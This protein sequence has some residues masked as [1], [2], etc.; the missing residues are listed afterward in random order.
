MG[1]LGVG[2][3]V[4][5]GVSKRFPGQE[6]GP[7]V[8]AVT[9]VD[10]SVDPGDSLAL[11]GPN[12]AGKSTVLKLVAGVT[13][14]SAG[15]VRRSGHTVAVIELGA[16]L[17][18]DLTGRENLR[19]L[20]DLARRPGSGGRRAVRR[21]EA[22]MVEFSGLGSAIDHPV[23]T[24]STGMVARLSFAV[25]AHSTPDLLLIDEVLSVGDLSF[26]EQCVDRLV[27][28]RRSGCS[29]VMV[30]HDLELV[31]RLCDRSVLLVAGRVQTDG[32][33]DEVVARYL[34]VRSAVAADATVPA[35]LERARLDA[36]EEVS[37]RVEDLAPS[38]ERLRLEYVAPNPMVDSDGASGIVFGSTSLIP[39]VPG[40]LRVRLTTEGLPPGRYDLHVVAET[41]G[42]GTL[43]TAVL[44]F[45]LDG[46]SGPNAIRLSGRASV[47]DGG[48]VGF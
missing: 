17:L 11:I 42:G 31:R 36:G 18:G 23:R 44:P 28:L 7:A 32:P 22:E 27:D 48:P 16:G 5:E 47:G 33:T 6:G 2:G 9:G 21:L 19:Q 38:V 3:L 1:R 12:G 20:A 26:Q 39:E 29:L 24:Y 8:D 41:A 14:P 25:A 40:S 35:T 30:S 13:A 4:L 43:G 37:L 15:Q 10:I 46:P 45:V 34:G